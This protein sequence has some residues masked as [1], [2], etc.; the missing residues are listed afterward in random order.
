MMNVIEEKVDEIRRVAREQTNQVCNELNAL[1]NALQEADGR[2]SA[3]MAAAA[4]KRDEAT[5]IEAMALRDHSTALG[6]IVTA[7]MDI[8]KQLDD[9]MMVTGSTEAP[10]KRQAKIR[11]VAGE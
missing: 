6:A 1:A 8:V 4:R 9:G 2:F 5:Q 11:A 10:T 7:A 3:S